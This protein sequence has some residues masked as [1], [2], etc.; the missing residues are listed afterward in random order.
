METPEKI[1]GRGGGGRGQ[2]RHSNAEKGLEKA[3]STTTTIRS[4]IKEKAIKYYGSI[5]KAIE[6][7]VTVAEKKTK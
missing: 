7:A 1:T 3:L 4:S 6:F 2:G 5:A